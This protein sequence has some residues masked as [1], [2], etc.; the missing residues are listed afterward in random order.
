[1][2]SDI[3]MTT[4]D[5]TV[6]VNAHREGLLCHPT[7]GSVRS[8]VAR[9]ISD[10]VRAEV[11]CIADRSDCLTRSTLSLAFGPDIAVHA[12][13]FGDLGASRNYGVL[14]AKGTYVAFIDADD[15][16]GESW[17]QRAYHAARHNSDEIV[18]H[19]Q[20]SVYFGKDHFS[21]I[22]PDMDE[23]GFSIAGLSVENYWTSLSFAHSSV[24]RTVPYPTTD[25]KRG[26]GFED[27]S[28]N[29][30]TIMAGYRH[31]IVSDTAHLIRRKRWS[32]S[33]ETVDAAAVPAQLG[34][35]RWQAKRS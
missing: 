14:N 24:Y 10:G 30:S 1:M 20:I 17:L 22:H 34:F 32:L 19:P 23:E 4:T 5:L 28:W 21:V 2:S 26:L 13:D 15:L 7:I 35:L 3:Q 8:A 6:I 31:K 25:L 11:L 16:W 33:S 29:M 9:L 27:W 12:V 18:W